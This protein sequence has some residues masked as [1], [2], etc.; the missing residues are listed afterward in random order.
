MVPGFLSIFELV[1]RACY[2]LENW[3]ARRAALRPTFLFRWCLVVFSRQITA[4]PLPGLWLS[5]K[6]RECAWWMGMQFSRC[7]EAIKRTSHPI[8]RWGWE[9]AQRLFQKFFWGPSFS[10]HEQHCSTRQNTSHIF[11]FHKL[12]WYSDT[13]SSPP[14]EKRHKKSRK[15]F[16]DFLLGGAAGGR[17]IFSF[18]S[19]C[20]VGQKMA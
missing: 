17:L 8:C 18:E 2:L 14:S 1:C 6:Q 20:C 4:Q 5:P 10:E 16:K 19:S 3:G 9:V 11:P 12:S 7:R 15:P 13:I